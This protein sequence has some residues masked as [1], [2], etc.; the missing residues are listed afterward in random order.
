MNICP[1]ASALVCLSANS[2]VDFG[3]RDGAEERDRRLKGE[4]VGVLSEMARQTSHRTLASVLEAFV[5]LD[6]HH[7]FMTATRD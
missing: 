1:Y 2:I 7:R 4:A 6:S 5:E 3:N